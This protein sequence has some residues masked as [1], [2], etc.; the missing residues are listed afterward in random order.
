MIRKR[1][2]IVNSKGLHAR[3]AVK[4]VKMAE[5]FETEITVTRNDITVSGRSIMG[6]M[7]LAAA[8][9]TRIELRAKG[10]GARVALEALAKLVANRFDED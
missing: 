1:V 2:T 9:G 10:R 6:L 7:T 5:G 3:A 4:F 8:P